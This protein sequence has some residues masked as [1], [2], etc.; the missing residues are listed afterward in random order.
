M[1]DHSRDVL[2]VFNLAYSN[3]DI[4]QV[5]LQADYDCLPNI[6]TSI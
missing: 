1:L 4:L 3:S 2:N 6:I 5:L